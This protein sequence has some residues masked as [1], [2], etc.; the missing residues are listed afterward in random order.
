MK[1]SPTSSAAAPKRIVRP[2]DAVGLVVG[3]VIG[4]GIFRTPSI[5]AGNAANASAVYTA[6]LV[7]GLISLVGALVYAELATTYPNAGGDYYYL[8]RAFGHRVAFLFG[9]SRMTVIQTG[10]LATVVFIF[11]DYASQILSLGEYSSAIYAA[12][13]ITI[14]TGINIMG[15]RE[16]TGTQNLLA[17]IQV[18]GMIFVIAAAFLLTSPQPIAPHLANSSSS[19]GLMLLFVLFT[20]GGW[21]EAA[22]VSGELREVERNMAPVLVISI[23][24]I[25]VLYT[26]MNWAYLH[27]LGLN[28]VAA[29]QQVA[30]DLMQSL[31]GSVGA[32]AV[33]GL[34][35]ISAL[36]TA[37]ATVFTG[38]RSSYALGRDYRQFRFLGRWSAQTGTPI[39]GLVLQGIIALAL[40]V[41]GVVAHQGFQAIVEYTAPVFW[42]F[43]LLSGVAL[44]VLRYKDRSIAR[45]FRVPLYPAAPILFCMTCGYLLYSSL[46]YTGI[47]AL[48]GV[49]VLVVGALWLLVVTPN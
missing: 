17:A 11:G 23:A 46:A 41:L 4:A 48:V 2:I 49:A 12:L 27:I 8:R 39:N 38:G 14:L 32:K 37:N 10:S 28:G 9:W 19:F 18:S 5:V 15:V 22:Y 33:S 36:T 31:L 30:A 21:N 47:G 1:Q 25:T 7:G 20:Y 44:I 35:A 3:I 24:L 26:A 16:G 40:I 42:S 34:V 43:F 13:A 45:P 29:S 6:W